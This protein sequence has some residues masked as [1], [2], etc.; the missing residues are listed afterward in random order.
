MGGV[1]RVRAFLLTQYLGG[2]EGLADEFAV[3]KVS[4]VD[5]Q[6]LT[7]LSFDP[8]LQA[9]GA[10]GAG[11]PESSDASSLRPRSVAAVQW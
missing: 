11:L 2:L 5:L 1:V 9:A 7:D 3:F 4:L 6:A 10:R 8:V